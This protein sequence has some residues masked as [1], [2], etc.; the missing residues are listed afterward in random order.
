MTATN[1]F[2]GTGILV[3]EAR[4]GPLIDGKRWD[5]TERLE[6]G[7]ASQQF[8]ERREFERNVLQPA[9]LGSLGIGG[10]AGDFDNRHTMTE[11]VVADE[12]GL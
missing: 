12:C 4:L 8:V 2:G 10:E 7:V 11:F 1:C 5:D 3:V 9:V 6:S